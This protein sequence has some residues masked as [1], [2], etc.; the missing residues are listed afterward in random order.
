[1][2][3]SDVKEL[4]YISHIANIPSVL[5][6]GILSHN[7]SS[8]LPHKSI[9]MEEI[10]DRR[11]NKN[12][13]G[14]KKQLHDYANLYFD[15]HNPMLCKR[16]NLNDSICILRINNTVLDL[17][18]VIVADKNASSDY[19]RFDTVNNGLSTIDKDKLFAEDW[20]HENRIEYF[21]HRS[22]KCA[23]VLV[24]DK[25]EPKYIIG[26]FVAN[27]TALIAFEKLKCGLTVCIK[28][29]IFF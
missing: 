21:A 5:K 24:P 9:A 14:T 20:R 27:Q 18:N 23:E 25:I 12:I 15:A 8:T 6:H 10:Q 17:P 4:Y 28:S 29:D 3:R 16:Q 13:P 22:A 11:R 19:V 1:L 26:A 7:H 2:E